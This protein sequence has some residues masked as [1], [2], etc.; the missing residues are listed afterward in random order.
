MRFPIGQPTNCEPSIPKSNRT[1]PDVPQ[2]LCP[3]FCIVAN[4]HETVKLNQVSDTPEVHEIPENADII[5]TSTTFKVQK[6]ATTKLLPIDRKIELNEPSTTLSNNVNHTSVEQTTAKEII[7]SSSPGPLAAD[8]ITNKVN[9]IAVQAEQP[10]EVRD[11]AIIVPNTPSPILPS[12]YS[13]KLETNPDDRTVDIIDVQKK[14]NK[15]KELLDTNTEFKQQEIEPDEHGRAPKFLENDIKSTFNKK[16][17]NK[18]ERALPDVELA[19]PSNGNVEP[20]TPFTQS[21][22]LITSTPTYG[23]VEA[24]NP[25]CLLIYLLIRSESF[26]M[27]LGFD[28]ICHNFNITYNIPLSKYM[29][30]NRFELVFA[31]VFSNAFQVCRPHFIR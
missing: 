31:W 26:N 1:L 15:P 5:E 22:Q 8:E 16:I 17:E 6:V 20:L 24:S 28:E 14:Q 12:N 3:S 4:G 29:K 11:S 19:K 18:F 25:A 30:E 10:V 9:K 7:D 13:E 23:I 2:A 21:S 27:T